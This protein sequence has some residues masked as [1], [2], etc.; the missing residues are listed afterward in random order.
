MIPI[1]CYHS[2]DNFGTIISVP[3]EVFQEQMACLKHNNFRTLSLYDAIDI[4]AGNKRKPQKSVVITFDDG[5]ESMYHNVFPVLNKYGF[6]ATIF[7][8]TQYIGSRAVWVDDFLK[9]IM[10]DSEN[11]LDDNSEIAADAINFNYIKKRL[12][13]LVDVIQR[14]VNK[15]IQEIRDVRNLALMSWEQ[16]REMHSRGIHFGAHTL[17]HP[18]LSDRSFEEM[19]D[20]IY[21]SK[22][23]IEKNINSKVDFFCYPYG[24]F[25]NQVAEIVKG[26]GFAGACSLDFGISQSIRERYEL[27]RIA[28][29]ADTKIMYFKYGLFS[30][31]RF[32]FLRNLIQWKNRI[33][34]YN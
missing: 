1:L 29:N 20:Q 7:L 17:T 27:K 3:V 25:S 10:P 8:T 6:S 24:D 4:I 32:S 22:N 33:A 13:N 23:I 19:K 31:F 14:D 11:V 21:Q 5:Y 18:F 12:P 30:L 15:T 9:K 34:K 28:I 26:S 16:I 2:V